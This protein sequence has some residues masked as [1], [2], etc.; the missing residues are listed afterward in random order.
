MMQQIVAEKL[1]ELLRMRLEI[2]DYGC[3]TGRTND[4]VIARLEDGFVR[5]CVAVC[6]A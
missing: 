2:S 3:V 1:D 4:R 5:Q 6:D